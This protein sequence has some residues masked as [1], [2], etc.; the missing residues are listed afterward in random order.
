[1]K[2]RNVLVILSVVAYASSSFAWYDK[3]DSWYY[4]PV[5]QESPPARYYSSLYS[6]AFKEDI[7][8]VERLLKQGA[9]VNDANWEADLNWPGTGDY[10]NTWSGKSPIYAAIYKKNMRIIDTLIKN[11]ADLNFRGNEY[12]DIFPLIAAARESWDIFEYLFQKGAYLGFD[13]SSYYVEK[14]FWMSGAH[15]MGDSHNI[16][17]GMAIFIENRKLSVQQL[18]KLLEYRQQLVDRNIMRHDPQL[19]SRLLYFAMQ[20]R[21]SSD[22]E[23]ELVIAKL[24]E[25]GAD[26]TY[27]PPK[28]Y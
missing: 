3:D 15:Y 17:G 4:T 13:D 12:H 1:M 24:I 18:E 26:G 10:Y 2:M 8:E 16:R 7:Q 21:T 27:V 23:H 5:E 14:I 6:A 11:G 28:D 25:L 19:L 22:S 20:V 9:N